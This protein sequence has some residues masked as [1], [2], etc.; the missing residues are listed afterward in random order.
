MN[1]EQDRREFLKKGLFATLM[2]PFLPR[3]LKA[4]RAEAPGG[5]GRGATQ[6]PKVETGEKPFPGFYK[7]MSDVPNVN[8]CYPFN[9][10]V[11]GSTQ[12]FSLH[13]F[14]SCEVTKPEYPNVWEIIDDMVNHSKARIPVDWKFVEEDK[15]CSDWEPSR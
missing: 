7:V 4:E 5:D 6:A 8:R 14:Q 15:S 2:A 11:I 3:W 1:K 13:V 12:P 10:S 9:A